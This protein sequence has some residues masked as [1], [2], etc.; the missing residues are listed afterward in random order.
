VGKVNVRASLGKPLEKRLRPGLAAPQGL[1]ELKE[2]EFGQSMNLSLIV[3][4]WNEEANLPQCL[5]SFAPLEVDMFVVDSGSTDGTKDE[6]R[7]SGARI[8]EHPFETHALQWAWALENLPLRT[9]WVIALD[10]DQSLTPELADELRSIFSNPV[11]EEIQGFYTNRRQIFRGRWL[12]HGGYYPKY[13]L[14][15]FRRNA[16]SFD[17]SD[18]AEHHF[19]VLVKTAKLR[20]DI[21]ED[22][23]KENDITFWI[24][25]HNR[26]A[27]LVAA[28]E[29]QKRLHGATAPLRASAFGSPD[30][31][32]LLK[33][34]WWLGLPL[35][36]RP[37]LFFLYRYIVQFG[38]MDG[39]EGF[40]FHFLHALWFRILVDIKVEELAVDLKSE[41]MKTDAR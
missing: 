29:H 31:R 9:D 39:K 40:L 25:K 18:I 21:V 34:R 20:N 4:T 22:N 28:E 6:A 13:L 19:Y 26:Y 5:R 27:T 12:K 32:T 35:Y 41:V 30:A 16:V 17:R 11:P 8:F 23:K 24:Q 36:V 37:I 14:K 1:N 15:I 3:L 33:K 2:K 7:R 10:A 38:W